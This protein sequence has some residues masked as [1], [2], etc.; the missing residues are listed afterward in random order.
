MPSLRRWQALA[1]AVIIAV[2]VAVV[3]GYLSVRQGEKRA[4]RQRQANYESSLRSYSKDLQPGATRR[5]VEALLR[6][7][8]T[9]F[10]QMCCIDSPW[11]NALD[12]LIKIGDETAPFH[13]SEHNVYVALS[14][15][16]SQSRSLPEANDSDVLKTVRVYHRFEGCL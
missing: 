5:E 8:G 11:S 6:N 15:A 14:F 9:A 1:P 4:E 3:A 12:D 13:C 16:P 10:R 2:L 7:R